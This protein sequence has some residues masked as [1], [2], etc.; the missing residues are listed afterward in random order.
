MRRVNS[1]G[2]CTDFVYVAVILVNVEPGAIG[3]ACR[4][5][6]AITGTSLFVGEAEFVLV[7]AASLFVRRGT[8]PNRADSIFC[9]L[10]T[11]QALFSSAVS[12]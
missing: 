7:H 8:I 1:N 6:G 9:T 5:T 4:C 3:S 2:R 12:D 10:L 11:R